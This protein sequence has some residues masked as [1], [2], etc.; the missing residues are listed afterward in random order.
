MTQ[1]AAEAPVVIPDETQP[2]GADG[3]GTIALN[4]SIPSDATLTG[5][6]EIQFPEG[7]TLDEQ[8]T[9]LSIDLS[10][11]FHL[12]FSYEGS[13]TWL[14]TILSNTLK[15]ST[16]TEYQKIMDIAYT[17][18][19]SVPTGTYEAT[20]TNLDFLLDSGIPLKDDSLS[21][22]VTVD[23]TITAIKTIGTPSVTVYSQGG[24]AFVKSDIPIRHVT[25]YDL[26]GR[27]LKEVKSGNNF[28]EIS[29]LP[30][31]QMLIVKVTGNKRQGTHKLRIEN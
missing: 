31:Q 12:S 26:S 11:N 14:I 29:G 6:F 30:K 25:V 16:A 28:V 5:S 1:D 3:K 27:L 18:N 10:G 17:V 9:V 21:V 4:L 8:L 13:N 15:S 19:D 2:A 23:R 20:I 7:M 22:P 24:N